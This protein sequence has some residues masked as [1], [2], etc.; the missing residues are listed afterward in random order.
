MRSGFLRVI[1]SADEG[2][3][4]G[5]AAA[6]DAGEKDIAHAGG[7]RIVAAVDHHDLMRADFFD[8]DPLQVVAVRCGNERGAGFLVFAGGGHAKRVGLAGEGLDVR[9]ERLE[10]DEDALAE[11]A[12]EEFGG[13]GAAGAVREAG[14]VLGRDGGLGSVGHRRS[15]RKCSRGLEE[16][17]RIAEG[18][19]EEALAPGGEG[20]EALAPGGEVGKRHVVGAEEPVIADGAIG[21]DGGGHVHVAFVG[22]GFVEIAVAAFDV[23]DVNHEDAFVGTELGDRLPDDSVRVGRHLGDGA[24][25]EVEAVA[26]VCGIEVEEAAH[27]FAQSGGED[28]FGEPRE[29]VPG[30]GFGDAAGSCGGDLA[31]GFGCAEGVR[32]LVGFGAVI[33]GA[34]GA[35]TDAAAAFDGAGAGDAD[36]L[37]V[38]FEGAD[39]AVGGGADIGADGFGGNRRRVRGDGCCR[40]GWR[41]RRG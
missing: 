41:R 1:L 16:G 13:D 6:G 24:L 32:G 36:H 35:A 29:G 14:E 2:L 25:A 30:L 39:P 7:A 11:A 8:G 10:L 19:G 15:P 38:V 23:A 22:E 28:L 18:E 31:A 26:G 40:A 12:A 34:E 27:A 21:V 9:V 4:G 33:G 20:E 17:A 3:A 37:E 5:G